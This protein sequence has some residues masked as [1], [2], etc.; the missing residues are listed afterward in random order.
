MSMTKL[1]DILANKRGE[2]EAQKEVISLA[3]I[4]RE[5]ETSKPPLN[6]LAALTMGRARPAL[7]AECKRASPSRGILA[8][9]LDPPSL[10]RIY[11]ENGATAVSV[12]TDERFFHG[13]LDDL[14][15]VAGAGLSI[16]V[17]RKDF[18]LDEY[19]VFEARAAGADSVLLIVAALEN[20][21]LHSLHEL[22]RQLGM[23]ALVEVHN[24]QEIETALVC[25]PQLIG[26][27][28][29]NLHD[30]TVK[31]E[32]S[33]ELRKAIPAEVGVVAE[34]GIK[35]TEDVRRLAEAGVDAILVGEALVTAADIPAKVRSLA[36]I[37]QRISG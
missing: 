5:A 31:L 20:E 29:R 19:Q 21:Q 13:S 16:P 27:N 4:Q 22:A 28:N 24:L 10:A 2:V 23:V 18:I 6:L 8:E 33:L 30:F 17:L 35:T 11:A 34:S 32:T 37:E 7:I 1:E 25:K 9:G 15:R 26:I 12:V 3:T 36:W 14:R